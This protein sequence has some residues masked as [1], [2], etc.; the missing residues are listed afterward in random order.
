[1]RSFLGNSLG[2]LGLVTASSRST[3]AYRVY[4]GRRCVVGAVALSLSSTTYVRIVHPVVDTA[5]HHH[6]PNRIER[7]TTVATVVVVR[8]QVDHQRVGLRRLR[9]VTGAVD[10][11]LRGNTLPGRAVLAT[12]AAY[13]SFDGRAG[14][15]RP[16]RST[17]SLILDSGHTDVRALTSHVADFTWSGGAARGEHLRALVL[18]DEAFLAILV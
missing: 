18:H 4:H 5:V 15:K 7:E 14:T 9:R 8:V 6:I 1:M 13:S 10:Q 17:T 2:Q 12:C 11:L 16:A 3:A